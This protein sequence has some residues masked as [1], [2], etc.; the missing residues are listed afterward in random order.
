M[1]IG[2]V[3]DLPLAVEALRRVLAQAPQHQVAWTA[4]DGVEAVEMALRDRP[5][6]ILMDL[7]MPRMNG[8]EATRRI[9]AEAPCAILVVTSDIESNAAQ[10]F[11][12]MGKGALDAVDTPLLH[13]APM[14]GKHPLL[15]KIDAVGRLIE[16]GSSAPAPKG[17]ERGATSQLIAIGASAGGPAALAAI[18]KELPAGFP[19]GIVIVQHV[20]ARFAQGLAQWLNDQSALSVRL[21]Q[22][23]DRVRPGEVLVAGTDD[24]LVFKSPERL[25]YSSEPS[26]HTYRPSIDV[27]FRS[28]GQFWPGALT[29]LLLTGMG[30]DGARGLKELRDKG[31]LTIAQDKASSAVYGMPKA[32]LQLDAAREVLPLEQIAR[33]LT[34]LP[35][36]RLST[37]GL[38]E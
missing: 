21:A 2:I 27:F 26:D 34:E 1:R 5:D 24:H 13:G 29:G 30:A 16:A 4:A 19:A 9:M 3:N 20:D 32:A 17:I 25:G 14:A 15:T 8:V 11:A 10:V 6:I 18:L 37:K 7:V 23:G 12:A 33:R 31:H 35:G 22:E 38:S 28:A 36:L